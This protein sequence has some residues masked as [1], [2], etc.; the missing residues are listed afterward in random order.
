ME[1]KTILKGAPIAD[2]DSRR[3]PGGVESRRMNRTSQ[4]EEEG[5]GPRST[6]VRGHMWLKQRM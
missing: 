4:A 2:Q 6:H 5:R 3:L 1:A